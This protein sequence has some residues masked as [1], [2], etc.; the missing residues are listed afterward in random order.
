VQTNLKRIIKV[1]VLLISLFSIDRGFGFILEQLYFSQTKGIANSLNYLFYECNADILVFGNSRAQHHYDATI[2]S[3][4][5]KMTCYN[6]GQDGGHS[7]LFSYAQIK[8]ILKR[9]NPKLII[10]EIDPS[11]MY[12]RNEDYD[13]LSILLPYYNEYVE[14]RP[15]LLAR[16]PYERIK[17]LSSIYPFNSKLFDLIWNNLSSNSRAVNGLNG[18]VPLKSKFHYSARSIEKKFLTNDEDKPDS[19]KIAALKDI[20]LS[21]RSKNV[22]ILFVNSP[23]YHNNGE[24]YDEQTKCSSETIKIINSYGANYLD[25]TSLTLFDGREDLFSDRG[26]LNSQGAKLFTEYLSEQIKKDS[27]IH[28]DKKHQI[29]EYKY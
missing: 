29:A 18:F 27:S 6:A 22:K 4:S 1:L 11:L 7:V 12:Y 10:V 5:L 19:F 16:S 14:L 15:L 24:I 20:I 3:D 23:I 8:I 28:G 13:K 17:L 25:F 9:Y 21:C 2:I 26:H